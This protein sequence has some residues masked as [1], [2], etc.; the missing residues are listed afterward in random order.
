VCQFLLLVVHSLNYIRRH[1]LQKVKRSFSSSLVH[2]CIHPSQTACNVFH[3]TSQAVR[4]ILPVRAVWLLASALEV[5]RA[6]FVL[7][8]DLTQ[9]RYHSI[10]LCGFHLLF[11]KTL[12]RRLPIPR[13]ASGKCYVKCVVVY[14]NPHQN[15]LQECDFCV[16]VCVCMCV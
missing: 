7:S 9:I 15:Y 2:I 10:C 5:C 16:R 14:L 1:V 11:V 3:F 12:Q 6:E 8:L 4:G 13:E